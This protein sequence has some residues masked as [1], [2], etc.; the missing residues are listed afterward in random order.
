MT[1]CGPQLRQ[2]LHG[3]GFWAV[4]LFLLP[5]DTIAVLQALVRLQKLPAFGVWG[6][7][8]K[9]VFGSV[10]RS[11]A[12]RLLPSAWLRALGPGVQLSLGRAPRRP[13]TRPPAARTT[14]LP[15][16]PAPASGGGAFQ[17]DFWER[18]SGPPV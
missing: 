8:V 11:D 10:T 16:T 12:P 2:P 3:Q 7:V 9:P 4:L 15:R 17:D 1:G 14:A 5:M 13:H 6:S 18:D